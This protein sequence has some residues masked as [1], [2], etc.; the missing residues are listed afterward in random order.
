MSIYYYDFLSE[1]IILCGGVH[2]QHFRNQRRKDLQQIIDIHEQLKKYVK[3][4]WREE[5]DFLKKTDNL[6]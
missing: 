1:Q 2:L 5:L 3:P 6:F 4:E